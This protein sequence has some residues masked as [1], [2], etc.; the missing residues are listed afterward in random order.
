MK[1]TRSPLISV[2]VRCPSVAADGTTECPAAELG[3]CSAA[4]GS[5]AANIATAVAATTAAVLDLDPILC[6]SSSKAQT[7]TSGSAPV[8][9]PGP[10]SDQELTLHQIMEMA[11]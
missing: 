4:A 8:C 11:H 7:S 1:P 9:G 10:C 6:T 5:P 3:S 2:T